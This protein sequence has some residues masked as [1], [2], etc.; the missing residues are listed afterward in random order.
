MGSIF[1]SPKQPKMRPIIVERPIIKPPT[2]QK[3]TQS[4]IARQTR[5]EN[6]LRRNRGSLST[7]LTGFDGFLDDDKNQ[8]PQKTLLG[9]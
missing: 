7:I 2:P 8:Q 4:E 6:L 9:E 1:S 3:P 5:E